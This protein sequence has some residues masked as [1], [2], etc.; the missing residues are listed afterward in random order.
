MGKLRLV[1]WVDT[2]HLGRTTENVSHPVP[3]PNL[4]RFSNTTITTV[5]Q[6]LR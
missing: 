5:V 3:N 6:H 2:P 4:A 1:S